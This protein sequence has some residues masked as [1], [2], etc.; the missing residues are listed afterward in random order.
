MP[1]FIVHRH[2]ALAVSCPICGTDPGLWC[3][4]LNGQFTGSLHKARQAEADRQFIEQYGHEAAI[5]HAASGWL[6]DP[7][8]CARD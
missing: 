3:R 5:I 4:Q 7:H 1:D 6:I 8:G 2:P